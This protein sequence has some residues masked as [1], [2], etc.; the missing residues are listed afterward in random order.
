MRINRGAVVILTVGASV[1]WSVSAALSRASVEEAPWRLG[2]LERRLETQPAATGVLE[3]RKGRVLA[4]PVFDRAAGKGYWIIERPYGR[5]LANAGLGSSMLLPYG[6]QGNLSGLTRTGAESLR[7]YDDSGRVLRALVGDPILTAPP[8]DT[9]KLTIDAELTTAIYN[10]LAPFG[11]KSAAVVL[12]AQTGDILALVDYPAPD[13]TSSNQPNARTGLDALYGSNLPASTFKTLSGTYVLVRH[14]ADAERAHECSGDRCWMRHGHV[15]NLED[16]LARSCNTWFRLESARWDRA[17]WLTFLLDTGL[18]PVDVPGLPLSPIVMVGHKGNQMHWP[19]AVGQQ[20]WTSIVGLAAAYATV[21]SMDGRRVNP[22]VVMNADFD[23]GRPEVVP[24][25][26]TARVR[27]MLRTTARIGTAQIVNQ[28]Y[29]GRDA[30]GK[31][32]T[33]EQDGATSDAIFVAVAPWNH[34]RCIVVVS[35]KGGGRGALAGRVAG[36]VLNEVSAR[37]S[38]TGGR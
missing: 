27:T 24:P 33:G 31:T 9:T 28:V 8:I 17:E 36:A 29:R 34:P 1:M 38:S 6:V 3:D 2:P 18:Q 25:A 21:T 13:V 5:P 22:S 10:N 12:D 32:G 35:L 23:R 30:G 20:V 14:P 15:R 4:R 11:G 16:A 7:P 19:Q 26:V 37:T